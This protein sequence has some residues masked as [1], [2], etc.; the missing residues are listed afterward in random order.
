MERC[1]KKKR[2]TQSGIN[3]RVHN[4]VIIFIKLFIDSL[5]SY[6]SRDSI[7]T[8]EEFVQ[9]CCFYLHIDFVYITIH[10]HIDFCL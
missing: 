10:I 8:Y 7:Y 2:S 3:Y 1:L 9:N 5:V 6:I 4:L